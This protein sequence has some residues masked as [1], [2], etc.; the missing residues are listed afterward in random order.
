M[1]N[2]VNDKFEHFLICCYKYDYYI[3]CVAGVQSK[4][5]SRTPCPLDVRG[6]NHFKMIK[7]SGS[8]RART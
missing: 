4:C 8:E 5:M 7:A 2:T 3:Q 6:S 1:F